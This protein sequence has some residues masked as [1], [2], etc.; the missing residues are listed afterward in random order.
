MAA[1]VFEDEKCDNYNNYNC[2]RNQRPQ[3]ACDD[4]NDDGGKPAQTD[5]KKKS[6]CGYAIYPT[7]DKR[8]EGC[9]SEPDA[10]PVA[11]ALHLLIPNL[12][13]LCCIPI[14]VQIIGKVMSQVKLKQLI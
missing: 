8:D 9:N 14:F 3:Y 13:F 2:Y 12:L 5:A 6:I 10:V 11:V 1:S 7:T 4:G